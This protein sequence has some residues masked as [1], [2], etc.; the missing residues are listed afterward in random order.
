MSLNSNMTKWVGERVKE[1]Q[2]ILADPKSTHTQRTLA[3]HVLVTWPEHSKDNEALANEL[4]C[5]WTLIDA[6]ATT[7]EDDGSISAPA[8]RS[9]ADRMRKQLMV[10]GGCAPEDFQ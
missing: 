8:W 2:E 1:A 7:L 9:H 5:A 10:H 4:M 6:H 3:R